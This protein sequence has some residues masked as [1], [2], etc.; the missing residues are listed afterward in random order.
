MMN[1]KQKG[2]TQILKI[3]YRRSLG[4]TKI[5]KYYLSMVQ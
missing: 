4:L 5:P 2:M 3:P 1:Y